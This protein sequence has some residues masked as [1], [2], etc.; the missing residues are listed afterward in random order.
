MS[1]G[2]LYGPAL[3]RMA[4]GKCLPSRPRPR[5]AEEAWAVLGRMAGLEPRGAQIYPRPFVD[6]MAGVY[7]RPT[8]LPRGG[9]G[10]LGG[11][12]GHPRSIGDRDGEV[13]RTMANSVC[14]SSV[15][16]YGVE[17]ILQYYLTVSP[18]SRYG[19]QVW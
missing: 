2:L 8:S 17:F 6:I 10:W 16:Q 11:S 12:P 18:N 13:M 1:L 15:L 3:F 5:G 9:S 14:N 4:S 7:I 19:G